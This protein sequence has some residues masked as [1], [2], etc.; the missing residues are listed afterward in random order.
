METITKETILAKYNEREPT[1]FYQIDGFHIPGRGDSVMVLDDDDDCIMG[2]V[3]HELMFG[4]DVRVLIRKE[5]ENPGRTER[6]IVRMLRK[7]ADTIESL[8]WVDHTT[9]N[10]RH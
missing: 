7:I 4:S 1:E 2:G 5:P 6:D 10:E 3:V 8:H 9:D